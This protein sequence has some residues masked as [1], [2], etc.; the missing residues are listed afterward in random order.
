MRHLFFALA[1]ASMVG[2]IILLVCLPSISPDLPASFSPFPLVPQSGVAS[3]QSDCGS[4]NYGISG[5]SGYFGPVNCSN[6]LNYSWWITWSQFAVL[7]GAIA[8]GYGAKGSIA[9]SCFPHYGHHSPHGHSQQ[10]PLL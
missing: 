2:W 8:V 6:F 3:F 10:L 7:C 1:A 4:Q 9:P 5:T